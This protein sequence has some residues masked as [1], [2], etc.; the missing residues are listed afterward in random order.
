MN[1]LADEQLK[2]M[3]PS[4]SDSERKQQEKE[5]YKLY[6]KLRDK[7]EKG[8]LG[9][10]SLQTRKRLHWLVLFIYIV[11]NHLGGFSY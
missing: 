8:F 11:K 10:I 4:I 9:K 5:F 6:Y 1:I 7:D 3:D 2:I